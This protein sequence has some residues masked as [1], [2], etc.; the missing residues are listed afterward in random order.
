L[1]IDQTIS[2]IGLGRLGLPLAAALSSRGFRVIGVDRDE[3][4]VNRVNS[5]SHDYVE[6]GLPALL[7]EI[8]GALSATSSVRDAVLATDVT[9]VIV[10]T[11]HKRQEIISAENVCE[12][13][14][15][16]GTVLAEKGSRHLV[17]LVSTSYPGSI[18]KC[19]IPHL[20]LSGKRCGIDFDFCY[21]P[22]FVMLGNVVQGFLRPDF[23]LI[24][25][26]DRRAGDRLQNLYEAFYGARTSHI[27]MNIASAEIAKLAL[28]FSLVAKISCANFF[29][30]LC[31]RTPGAS[32]DDITRLLSSDRRIGEGFLRGGMPYGGRC[33]PRDIEAITSIALSLEV[34][35]GLPRAMASLNERRFAELLQ[36]VLTQ[37]KDADVSQLAIG[38]LGLSFKPG[39]DEAAGSAGM[40][41]AETLEGMRF[42][43]LVHDPVIRLQTDTSIRQVADASAC[44]LAAEIVVIATPWRIYESLPPTLFSGKRVI[45]GWQS[46]TKA[47]K[48]ACETYIALGTGR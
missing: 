48:D 35:T 37:A 42:P 2:V 32:S 22:E 40:W 7:R 19:V 28:N 3:Q 45:D 21:S 20:E 4:R 26:F 11:P 39:T 18:M 34:D 36:F 41:L 8:G 47:Q 12:V 15:G 23:T 25:E 13:M 46:L 17:V 14:N 1:S 27:R 33:F 44:V 29:A 16:A 6:P 24:G 30:Q 43:V 10:D 38:I 9:F 31:E 5:Q